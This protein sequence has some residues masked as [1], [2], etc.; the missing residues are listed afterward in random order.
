MEFLGM[1]KARTFCPG[2]VL[3]HIPDQVA[4]LQVFIQLFLTFWIFLQPSNIYDFSSC[5]YHAHISQCPEV[6]KR[7]LSGY[8]EIST[9]A[10]LY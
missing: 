9:F 8:Y 1:L 2:L 10:R 3:D 6:L 7:V 5:H 4:P